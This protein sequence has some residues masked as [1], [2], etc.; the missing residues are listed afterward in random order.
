MFVFSSFEELEQ[1]AEAEPANEA[2]VDAERAMVRQVYDVQA[3]S[4]LIAA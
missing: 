4:S 3:V 2:A 1:N